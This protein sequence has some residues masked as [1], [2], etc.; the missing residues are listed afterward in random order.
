MDWKIEYLEKDGIVSAKVAGIMDWDQHKRFAE[1]L[2]PLAHK[3]GSHK[4]LI[5]FRKMTPNFTILQ[6]DDLPKL[7]KELGVG[8]EFRIASIYDPSTPHSSEFVF[9][10]NVSTITS[11]KVKL[12][13]SPD[14]GL[15]WLKAEK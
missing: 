5:D 13:S 11:I 4:I 7:L 14:E 2:Y 10:K 9:F 1:E 8:P 3:H 12:F 15:A 6:V